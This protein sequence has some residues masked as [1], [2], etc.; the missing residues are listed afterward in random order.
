MSAIQITIVFHIQMV[1]WITGLLQTDTYRFTKYLS[2]F[3][4]DPHFNLM[5]FMEASKED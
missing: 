4:S 3:Y 1:V 5:I 2:L